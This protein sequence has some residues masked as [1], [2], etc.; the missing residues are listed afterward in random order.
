MAQI[1][2]GDDVLSTE[3]PALIKIDVEGLETRVISGLFKT[4]ERYLPIVITEVIANRLE[5]AGSSVGDLTATMKS[6]GYEGFKL[7]LKKTDKRYHWCLTRF[8]ASETS[9]DIVWLNAGVVNHHLMLKQRNVRGSS[10]AKP[11]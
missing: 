6:L 1:R 2:R 7:E 5:R 8:D 10:R 9:C 11:K 3:K 4:I